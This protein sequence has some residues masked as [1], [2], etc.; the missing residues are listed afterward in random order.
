M[1]TDATDPAGIVVFTRT[2]ASDYASQNIRVNAVAPGP[3]LTHRLAGLPPET[4]EQ[5]ARAVSMGRP[6]LPEEAM[7]YRTVPLADIALQ[8]NPVTRSL[9]L[10]HLA[11]KVNI[12]KRAGNFS[13][14]IKRVYADAHMVAIVYSIQAPADQR[15]S[16][17]LPFAG[18]LGPPPQLPDLRDQRGQEFPAPLNSYGI[19][20]TYGTGVTG[21]IAD[22][23]LTYSSGHLLDHSAVANLRLSV[24]GI[25]AIEGSDGRV[26]RVV[27]TVPG[28]FVFDL[29][30]P[31]HR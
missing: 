25:T 20:S 2:A 7:A 12:T 10:D 9:V 13:L 1:R 11:Q 21:G 14:S 28:P 18:G 6:G 24:Q 22:G 17:L 26:P 8:L 4:R 30:I 16:S 3:T 5:V 19:G 29:T 23:V 31:V 15:F 27:A